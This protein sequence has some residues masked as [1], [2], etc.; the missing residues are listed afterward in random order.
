MYL[1]HIN[2]P[3][4]AKKLDAAGCVALADEIRSAL[5]VRASTHGGHFGPNFGIIEA[6]IALHAV[7]DSPHDHIVWDVSHQSYPHKMLTGR[8]LAFLDPA[9]YD[10]VTGFSNPHES[11]HDLFEVGHT[12]TSVSLALGLAKAR[13]LVGDTENIIAVIGDGS[14][15]GGEALEGLNVAGSELGSNFIVVVND[16][17]MSIAENHGG[18]YRALAELRRTQG[19]AQNNL[20]RALGFDYCYV[21]KGND[22]NAL[23]EAFRSVKD[24][25]H[26]VVVHI[27]TVKGKGYKPAETNKEGWHYHGPFNIETGE[28]L[29]TFSG[30]SYGEL[31]G[32]Y[33]E[34]RK[35]VDPRL[36]VLAAATPVSIGMDA[37]R[38]Q[39][40]GTHYLDVG[41]AEE[42]AVA[43]A[44][45]AAKRGA[46]VVW[47]S[48]ATFIQRTYDQLSQDL[49]INDNPAV[50][51]GT[52]G[53]VWGATDITH[54]SFTSIPMIANIPGIVYLS[55]TNAEEYLA[56]LEWGLDQQE[57]PV[58]IALPGGPV[59]HATGEVRR[60]YSDIE[61]Y[62]VVRRGSK[63]AILAL[64][65]FFDL[66]S[67][68]ADELHQKMGIDPTLI[69]PQFASGLD[70]EL[71]DD[72]SRDHELLLTLEDGILDGGF[73]QRVAGYMGT[74][75][76][77][78]ASYG[79]AKKK[80]D[81]FR[82][83]EL[84][85]AEHLTPE[86]LLADV[87]TLLAGDSE[88]SP[89]HQVRPLS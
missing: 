57:H 59:R 56:M 70:R 68:F 80:Y 78:V 20:F 13:D 17:Q 41:I 22:V 53:S 11:G 15:S 52:G 10:D 62:R 25:D 35:E 79:F 30:E 31:T 51:V 43:M 5:L 76:V 2:S 39:R 83:E 6:T 38:R 67:Q 88:A 14:L 77:R 9:H 12:S 26:P 42:T 65:S 32:A 81:R 8:K 55:P 36:L 84:M 16:N 34:K 89:T 29:S 37:A 82:A 18:I 50:I 75:D 1:E 40:M 73:G 54:A 46:H 60:D 58:Y 66:G 72:L 48:A 47:G 45:G 61:R 87:E 64:G 7:F 85:R 3:Q 86:L 28:S 4:D 27:N 21:E 23:I 74:R 33:L 63:V 71:L 69:N 49:A 44:S 19:T 24:V